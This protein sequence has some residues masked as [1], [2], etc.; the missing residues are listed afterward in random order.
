MSPAEP[1]KLQ[2]NQNWT[3][4][5]MEM[6]MKALKKRKRN[7]GVCFKSRCRIEGKKE[8]KITRVRCVIFCAW[9]LE[10]E[11]K[12]WSGLL[13]EYLM[14]FQGENLKASLSKHRFV[15]WSVGCLFISLNNCLT[16]CYRGCV[17]AQQTNTR[18]KSNAFYCWILIINSNGRFEHVSSV[19][20]VR[21]GSSP[22]DIFRPWL[23]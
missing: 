14:M 10:T 22:S 21:L 2:M 3:L 23:F 16:D 19:F 11:I 12:S 9:F 20:A 7:V 4:H 17:P 6:K 15:P 18:W 13:K 5:Q 8:K 1:G